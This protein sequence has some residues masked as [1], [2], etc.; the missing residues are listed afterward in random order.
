[1]LTEVTAVSLP[2]AVAKSVQEGV[3]STFQTICGGRPVLVHGEGLPSNCTG[4]IGIISFSGKPSWTFSLGIPEETAPSLVKQFAGFEI[5]F[6]S[7]DMCDVVGELTNVIAGDIIAQMEKHRLK[8]EMSLPMVMRGSDI[9]VATLAGSECLQRSW[10]CPQGPFW[11]MVMA[12]LAGR[13]LGRRSG[14]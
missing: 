2:S 12:A 13:V 10:Q 5:P 1:M 8:V 14:T 11:Y 3:E 9:E 6:D 7:Q 4:I